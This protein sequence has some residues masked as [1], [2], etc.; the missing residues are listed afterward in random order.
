MP[1]PNQQ[2]RALANAAALAAVGG[3]PISIAGINL[4]S[5]SGLNN[6]GMIMDLSGALNGL[7][8]QS[9]LERI[10]AAGN[11]YGGD[12]GAGNIGAPGQGE[13]VGDDGMIGAGSSRQPSAITASQPTDLNNDINTST[14]YNNPSSTPHT[15]IPMAD[16]LTGRL[17]PNDPAVKA[18]TEAALAMDKS[19][20]PRP[21]KCPLCDRAFYRLEHQ[22]SDRLQAR[23][24]NWRRSCFSEFWE[25][26]PYGI[27][28]RALRPLQTRH[29]RTHTGEKPHA[30]NHPGCDK[31][32]SRSDELT[33]H[34]RIHLPNA[35]AAAMNAAMNANANANP[36]GTISGGEPSA[37]AVAK[38]GSG[39]GP[40]KGK[41]K[42]LSGRQSPSGQVGEGRGDYLGEVSANPSFLA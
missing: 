42:S 11:L 39:S 17:D 21:Y 13:R 16:P 18:L 34:A 12:G 4:A 23:E 37:G 2:Q 36:T 22:V 24:K 5:G 30:C 25:I 38:D 10:K 1:E 19:K 26:T 41:K 29:I 32:F 9:V 14:E 15:P 28:T 7:N 31:R 3:T 8:G 40:G 33:R 6:D 20:I 35:G 27:L